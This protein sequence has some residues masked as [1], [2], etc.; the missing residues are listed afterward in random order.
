MP[1]MRRGRI[2]HKIRPG[3]RTPYSCIHLGK[4]NFFLG[5]KMPTEKE[6]QRHITPL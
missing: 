4:I 6:A 3:E 1:W 2:Y 5:N